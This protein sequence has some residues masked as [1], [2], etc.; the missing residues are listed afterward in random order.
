[1]IGNPPLA[2]LVLAAG[3][4]VRFGGNKLS[5]HFR[6]EPLIVH[7][8]RAARAA[9]VERVVVVAAAQLDIGVQDNPGPPVTVALHWPKRSRPELPL[10]AIA[11]E[12][13]SS[14]AT[15]R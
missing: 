6:G 11:P 5:A 3:A 10:S 4:G 13:S 9:P 7:A 2:A 15:C 8:V 1:M 14:S 12:P